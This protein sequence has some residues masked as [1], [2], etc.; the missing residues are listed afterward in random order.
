MKDEKKEA[1]DLGYEKKKKVP[2]NKILFLQP[3]IIIGSLLVIRFNFLAFESNKKKITRLLFTSKNHRK[4]KKNQDILNS[5]KYSW[6]ILI[7]LIS[8]PT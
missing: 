3:S 8:T 4:N 6:V 5:I 7:P 1:H 2:K